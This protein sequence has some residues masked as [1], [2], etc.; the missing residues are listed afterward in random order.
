MM[1]WIVHR[2]WHHYSSFPFCQYRG[3]VDGN[4]EHW[5]K[6][7]RLG[8]SVK[9]FYGNV[10]VTQ[11]FG[12]NSFLLK[13]SSGTGW[14]PRSFQVTVPL[15]FCGV[16]GLASLTRSLVSILCMEKGRV[17]TWE[18]FSYPADLVEMICKAEKVNK[19]DQETNS[20]R[21]RN[22]HGW[23]TVLIIILLGFNKK[24]GSFAGPRSK[25][26]NSER[27]RTEPGG[28]GEGEWQISQSI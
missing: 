10:W 15:S 7:Q 13:W 4:T 12:G 9:F 20:R 26:L 14:P 6:S 27:E 21:D 25:W 2:G 5:I 18:R 8:S 16:N 11:P 1:G 22:S 23:E 24:K 17:Q 19:W 28:G 3:N